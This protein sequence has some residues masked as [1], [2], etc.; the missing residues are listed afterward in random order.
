MTWNTVRKFGIAIGLV[1]ALS[2]CLTGGT[3]RSAKP[4]DK[5]IGEWG[6]GWTAT[7]YTPGDVTVKYTDSQGNSKVQVT[8]SQSGSVV[9][10]D[11]L[12]EVNYHLGV[13]DNLE[14]GGRVSLGALTFEADVKYRFLH[15]GALH[16]AADPTFGYMPLGFVQIFQMTLPVLATYEFSP[17]IALLASAKFGYWVVSQTSSSSNQL[18]GTLSGGGP[19]VGGALGVEFRGKTFAMRPFFDITYLM[20]KYTTTY[21]DSQSSFT[22][23]AD[24]S[25]GLMLM[26][27]GIAVSWFTGLELEKLEHMD[28][29][30]DRIEKKLDDQNKP[31][32]PPKADGQPDPN[33]PPKANDQ[34]DPQG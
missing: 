27:F 24:A 11:I 6:I 8:P 14:V 16:V 22:S 25:A 26:S 29:K 21:S 28:D 1:T 34:P 15:L 30:L 3:L 13:A 9:I 4:L 32:A 12:P 10:P 2:G 18:A 5:G 19:S 23:T 31:N 20:E 7:R 17:H 33:T